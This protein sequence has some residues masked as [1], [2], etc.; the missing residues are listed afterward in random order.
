MKGV[1]KDAGGIFS[2]YTVCHF[3]HE[4]HT[5]VQSIKIKIENTENRMNHNPTWA[6]AIVGTTPKNPI[7]PTTHED[8]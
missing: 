4:I 2:S 7:G 8:T 3:V 6:D 1:S 5:E